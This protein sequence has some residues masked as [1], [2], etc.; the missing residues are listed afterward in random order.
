MLMN[1]RESGSQTSTPCFWM[2]RFQSSRSINVLNMFPL[3]NHF[4]YIMAELFFKPFG[5]HPAMAPIIFREWWYLIA[6]QYRFR[7]ASK[8]VQIIPNFLRVQ[9]FEL[10]E[11]Q[12]S[13]FLI[14][15]FVEPFTRRQCF[16]DFESCR[17]ASRRARNDNSSRAFVC[18]QT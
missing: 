6:K 3:Y 13:I 10:L 15:Y 18:S 11:E 7:V 1:A 5:H 16:K 17:H 8:F 12:F 14:T 4:L 9:L 2:V